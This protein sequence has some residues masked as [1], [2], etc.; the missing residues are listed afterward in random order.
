MTNPWEEI[1]LDEVHHQI[2]ENALAALM[3]EIGSC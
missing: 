1:R 3:N 2:E